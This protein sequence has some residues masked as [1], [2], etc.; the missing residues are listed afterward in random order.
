MMSRPA[1][2]NSVASAVI[3]IVGEGLTRARRSARKAMMQLQLKWE[4]PAHFNA[5]TPSWEGD[6]RGGFLNPRPSCCRRGER[7]CLFLPIAA[8][9]ANLQQNFSLG[10]SI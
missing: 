7:L 10:C 1:A 2:F 8:S 6:P 3:A 9:A 5:P 4:Q